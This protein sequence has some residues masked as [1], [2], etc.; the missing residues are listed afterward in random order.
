[1]IRLLA[2]LGTAALVI[3][4]ANRAIETAAWPAAWGE[5]VARVGAQVSEVLDRVA[6]AGDPAPGA[7]EPEPRDPLPAEGAAEPLVSRRAFEPDLGEQETRPRESGNPSTETG[8]PRAPAELAGA[9]RLSR[10]EAEEIRCRLD[11][12]MD[13]ARGP[14]R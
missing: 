11:R 12:V 4:G 14:S 8:A 2:T 9:P 1:M 10:V 7:G 3:W 13:L 6:R 5:P